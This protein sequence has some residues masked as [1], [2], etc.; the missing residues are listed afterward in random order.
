MQWQSP[1]L[2]DELRVNDTYFVVGIF[3]VPA[4]W[5]S[6]GKLLKLQPHSFPLL[7]REFGVNVNWDFAL[8]HIV[9]CGS[10]LKLD[11]LSCNWMSVPRRF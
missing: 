8:F 5:F 3:V 2:S 11:M 9:C 10:R 4:E 1:N 7:A 6:A